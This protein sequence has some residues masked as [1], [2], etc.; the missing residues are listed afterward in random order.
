MAR[1]L[2]RSPAELSAPGWMGDFMSPDRLIPAGA[3]LDAAQFFV[4][5]S[6]LVKLS[7]AAAAD[8]VAIVFDTLTGP[9]P[10]GTLLYFGESKEFAR[11]TAAAAAGATTVAVEA[12]PSGLE[13][14]DEAR[15][16]GTGT[17]L[18]FVPSGT[19][20]GRTIAERDAN[21]PWGPADAADA[22]YFLTAHDVQDVDIQPDVALYRHNNVVKENYLPVFTTLAAG[23]I[24]LIRAAYIC[25]KGVD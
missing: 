16:S 3:R 22:E 11:T 19:L 4:E 10:S 1:A 21:S 25:Q 2:T 13:D 9:I 24:A 17:T 15:Y 23:V 8:D 5:D 18:K 6:V 12:L 20:I 7:A 14:N